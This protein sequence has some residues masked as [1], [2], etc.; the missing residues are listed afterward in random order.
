MQHDGIIKCPKSGGDICYK[1]QNTP[2]IT[3][4]MSLSCGFWTNSLMKE[5]EEFYQQQTETLPELYKDLA[6]KD[7]ETGLTWI[8]QTVNAEGKGMVFPY[9]SNG[10]NWK[11]A[12]VK[13]R[14]VTEEEQLNST[15]KTSYK[16]DMNTMKLFEEYEYVAALDYIGALE[17]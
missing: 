4:Y 8:P 11:W 13:S 15:L 1:I 10:S 16:T 6:W 12:S 3:T 5:G 14:P 9:G 2:E 17:G 7:P